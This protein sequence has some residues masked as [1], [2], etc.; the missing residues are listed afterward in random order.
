MYPSP[1]LNMNLIFIYHCSSQAHTFWTI[2]KCFITY[3]YTFVATFTLCF[4]YL[5]L[6]EFL[7]LPVENHVFY[8]HTQ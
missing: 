8:T 2:D 3:T 5:L 7:W 4:L 1:N 6:D